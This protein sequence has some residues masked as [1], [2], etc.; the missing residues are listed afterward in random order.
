MALV[1]FLSVLMVSTLR[2]SSFKEIGTRSRSMR[3]VIIVVGFAM[4][5]VLYSRHVLLALATGY[6]LYGLLARAV[7]I[8][9]RRSEVS[10][11]KVHAKEI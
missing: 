10:K 11:P 6:I 4:L 7:G 1:G 9:R 8:F 5:V 2:F 3:T